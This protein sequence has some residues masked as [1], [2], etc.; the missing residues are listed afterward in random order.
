MQKLPFALA[1]GCTVVAKP[2]EIT[3]GSTVEMG[4]L[5][6][7]AGLPAGVFNV[8]TGAGSVVGTV[9][10]ES[11]DVDMLSFTG[12][13]AV[14]S[15][16]SAVAAPSAKRLSMELGGKAASIV[17]PDADLDAA[18]EG[19]LFG[20]LFNTGECCVSGA[21]LLVHEAIA[22]QFLATLVERARSVVIGPP[23]DESAEI[24]ALIHEQHLGEVLEKVETARR[25]GASVLT[26][27]VRA[28]GD[29][30]A[31][32][33]FLE[34]T[35]VD[36]VSP[37]SRLFHEEVFGPVLAVTRFS[38][39]DEAVALANAVDYGLANSVWS[40]DI[41]TA[42]QTARRLRSGTVWVNTT[43]DG[44]P[45]LPGGGVKRSGYGREM[46]VAGYEEFTEVKTIQVRTGTKT[47]FFGSSV[48][49]R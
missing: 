44:A 23:L 34:P 9:L 18:A 22:D 15:T 49:G 40:R 38:T 30:L 29:G 10:S 12:S 36:H 28:Q 46:G 31:D 14:G 1:A 43:I 24:G 11:F 39:P 20:V 32:G 13:T 47:P 16:I 25:Q 45:Q 5:C 19:V 33:L 8:V 21:R 3:S 37:D 7:E 35:I 4:R 42:L 6:R 48:A 26:G 41:D 2:A 17:F 27:G